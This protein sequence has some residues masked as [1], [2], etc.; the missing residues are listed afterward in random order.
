MYLIA[1]SPHIKIGPPN[2]Y[3]MKMKYNLLYD[4]E[5]YGHY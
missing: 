1:K 5:L 2:V 4:L 3:T